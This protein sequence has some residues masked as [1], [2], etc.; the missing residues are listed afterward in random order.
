MNFTRVLEISAIPKCW[1]ILL[2]RII[3]YLYNVSAGTKQ[4]AVKVFYYLN[5]FIDLFLLHLHFTLHTYLP[6][7]FDQLEPIQIVDK[8]ILRARLKAYLRCDNDEGVNKNHNLINGLCGIPKKKISKIYLREFLLA[9]AGH[10]PPRPTKVLLR[11][12]LEN[13]TC[14]IAIYFCNDEELEKVLPNLFTSPSAAPLLNGEDG[15]EAAR[16]GLGR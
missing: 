4:S 11:Q 1:Q 14:V 2:I 13:S 5:R 15:P 12:K 7:E 3:E 10:I 8:S 9:S 16:V 6:M